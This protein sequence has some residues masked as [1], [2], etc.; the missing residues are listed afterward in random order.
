MKTSNKNTSTVENFKATLKACALAKGLTESAQSAISTTYINDHNAFANYINSLERCSKGNIIDH[1][2]KAEVKAVQDILG[3][4]ACQRL[5][6][7]ITDKK[8]KPTHKLK[9]KTA[10][11]TLLKKGL[12]SIQQKENKHYIWV[13]EEI[14]VKADITFEEWKLNQEAKALELFGEVIT[15][16]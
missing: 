5:A 14:E 4:P 16:K 3:K 12:C 13:L 11:D 7:E 1:G 6:F 8:E 2:Q 10:N 9:F 15:I